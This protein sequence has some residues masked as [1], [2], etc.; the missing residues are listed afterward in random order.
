MVDDKKDI[1]DQLGNVDKQ[2]RILINKKQ[3]INRQMTNLNRDMNDT[4]KN[5]S[6]E[7]IK[8]LQD[9][10]KKEIEDQELIRTEIDKQQKLLRELRAEKVD[11]GEQSKRE[12]VQIRQRQAAIADLNKTIKSR[13]T[14]KAEKRAARE[15][16]GDLEYEIDVHRES[17]TRFSLESAQK[18][19]EIQKVLGTR[20]TAEVNLRESRESVR[21]Y[22]SN[23]SE[24]EKDSR[25][26]QRQIEE[27]DRMTTGGLRRDLTRGESLDPAREGFRAGIDIKKQGAGFSEQRQY[28]KVT[29]EFTS[30]FNSI[31]ETKKSLADLKEGTEEYEKKQEEL[32]KLTDSAVTV[33]KKLLD[34]EKRVADRNRTGMVSG[35]ISSTM[36]L[37]GD[38]FRSLGDRSAERYVIEEERKLAEAKLDTSYSRQYM[39]RGTSAEAFLTTGGGA[40]MGFEAP[41]DKDG[42]LSKSIKALGKDLADVKQAAPVLAIGADLMGDLAEAAPRVAGKTLQAAANASATPG[43]GSLAGGALGF[44]GATIEEAGNIGGK[45]SRRVATTP[46]ALRTFQ[47]DKLDQAVKDKMSAGI[48]SFTGIMED[49]GNESGLTAEKMKDL[50]EGLGSVADPMKRMTESVFTLQKRAAETVPEVNKL[51]AAQVDQAQL[52][53]IQEKYAMALAPVI[54]SYMDKSSVVRD[55]LRTRYMAPPEK[56]RESENIEQLP[57]MQDLID[58]GFTTEQILGNRLQAGRTLGWTAR[59]GMGNKVST[60]AMQMESAGFGPAGQTI[61]SAAAIARTGVQ[62]VSSV[63]ERALQKAVSGGIRDSREFQELIEAASDTSKNT[64]D[65]EGALDRL[66]MT[67]GTGRPGDVRAARELIQTQD[68]EWS[69]TTGTMTDMVKFNTIKKRVEGLIISAEQSGQKV[70]D[71]SKQ[72]LLMLQNLKV[73]S[74]TPDVLKT[75]FSRE[76]MDL[77][78]SKA[79][80]QF[81]PGLTGELSAVQ[82]TYGAGFITQNMDPD[83]QRKNKVLQSGNSEEIRKEF[84]SQ[85]AVDAFLKQVKLGETAYRGGDVEKGTQAAQQAADLLNAKLGTKYKAPGMPGAVG[86]S[87]TYKGIVS[88]AGTAETPSEAV[89]M[90]RAREEAAL[91]ERS[92]VELKKR[93]MSEKGDQAENLEAW[94]Q[95]KKGGQREELNKTIERSMRDKTVEIKETDKIKPIEDEMSKIIEGFKKI[96]ESL[97]DISASKFAMRVAGN[98]VIEGAKAVTGIVTELGK[99]TVDIADQIGYRIAESARGA[100]GLST[101]PRTPL[102]QTP[103]N[104]PSAPSPLN[105]GGGGKSH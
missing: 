38:S 103:V 90:S 83:F 54:Q 73:S 102:F 9:A 72:E 82:S 49:V 36:G 30:L 51:Q 22:K 60:T 33:N 64:G 101:A 105:P 97:K 32:N 24:L 50:K 35:A 65:F 77:L 11:I 71:R 45:L 40:A 98:V 61:Q 47:I 2:S 81:L 94:E 66:L 99:S 89:A 80:S 100:V 63:L 5:A 48:D 76:T 104:P 68:Q 53:R 42:N 78:N 43:L 6:L 31:K 10:I 79:G 46:E 1:K 16:K 87:D 12:I 15:L 92:R 58:R 20:E 21:D 91:W 19:Q 88:T 26:R 70:S 7:S 28:A 57:E 17:A 8:K 86:V 52:E 41:Y 84:G 18:S 75:M 4:S 14:P 29:E 62:D 96:Q 13:G 95:W 56:K 37:V 74:M 25:R 44:A 23:A 93:P 85:S 59:G 69:G 34:I 55:T 27:A 3:D 67:T 39:R